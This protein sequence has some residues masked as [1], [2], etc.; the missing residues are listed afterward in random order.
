MMQSLSVGKGTIKPI[1][2]MHG[3]QYIKD[4]IDCFCSSA[5]ATFVVLMDLMHTEKYNLRQL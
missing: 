3:I 5:F 4:I 1:H 2:S